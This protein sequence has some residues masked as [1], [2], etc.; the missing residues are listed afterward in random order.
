MIRSIAAVVLTCLMILSLTGCNELQSELS[1]AHDAIASAAGILQPVNPDYASKLTKV[2]NDIAEVENLEAQYNA[3]AA[4]AKPG[5]A[6][7]V[8]A[9]SATITANLKDILAAVNV[10]NPEMVEYISVGVAIANSVIVNIA[11]HLPTTAQPATAQAAT[12]GG[13]A[14]PALPTV[15]FDNY[16]DLKK[17]WNNKVAGKFPNAKI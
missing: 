5:I 1:V 6:N 11:N 4:S 7:Q 2:A 17:A 10:H 3:A 8:Q 13:V 15:P 16:K 14:Q 9:V 12:I